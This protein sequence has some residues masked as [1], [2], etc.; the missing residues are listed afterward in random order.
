MSRISCIPLQPVVLVPK[1]QVEPRRQSAFRRARFGQSIEYLRPVYA[2][3]DNLIAPFDRDLIPVLR[4]LFIG[5]SFL[6]ELST[7][8]S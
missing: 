3:R 6:A 4:V 5:T 7:L 2:D 1:Q 8:V